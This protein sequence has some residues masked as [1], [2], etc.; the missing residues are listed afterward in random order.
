MSVATA[1][2][3]VMMGRSLGAQCGV[4]CPRGNC[5]L[6]VGPEGSQGPPN[7]RELPETSAAVLARALGPR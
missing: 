6:Q 3:V 7:F 1:D 5:G 4:V 2:Y